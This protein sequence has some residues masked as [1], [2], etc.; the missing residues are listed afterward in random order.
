MM[1]YKLMYDKASQR[2]I[3]W[4]K[5]VYYC[6]SQLARFIWLFIQSQPA[7]LV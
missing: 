5:H 1:P 7:F 4:A 3:K 2:Y 6:S